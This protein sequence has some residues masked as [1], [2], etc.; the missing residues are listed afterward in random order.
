M[1]S[2]QG[3]NWGGEGREDGGEGTPQFAHSIGAERIAV[4]NCSMYILRT[5]LRQNI[6]H[7]QSCMRLT[8]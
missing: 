1:V 6:R 2:V 5:H 3:S 4:K 8:P 7:M